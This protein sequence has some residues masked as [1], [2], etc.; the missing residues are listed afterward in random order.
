M[1]RAKAPLESDALGLNP[2]KWKRI[3]KLQKAPRPEP[4]RLFLRQAAC[5]TS[6]RGLLAEGDL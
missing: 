1:A 5:E 6:R 3:S 2:S 4:R